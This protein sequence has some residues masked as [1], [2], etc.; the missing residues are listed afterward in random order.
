MSGNINR[1]YPILFRYFWCWHCCFTFLVRWTIILTKSNLIN[2]NLHFDMWL[3]NMLENESAILY[4]FMIR[5]CA[6]SSKTFRD[7]CKISVTDILVLNRI[8]DFR[9]ISVWICQF[10]FVRCNLIH[11]MYD[12]KETM[13]NV[14]YWITRS[15]AE[16]CNASHCMLW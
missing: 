15:Y 3:F 9:L 1:H 7:P 12:C 6:F 2:V 5:Y 13:D 14:S 11:L 4:I 10:N 16:K 8:S